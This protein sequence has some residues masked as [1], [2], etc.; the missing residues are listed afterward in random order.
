[1][2]NG[3][4]TFISTLEDKNNRRIDF[5]RWS[6]KKLKTVET[7]VREFYQSYNGL[8][9]KDAIKRGAINLKIYKTEFNGSNE[10][11][12]NIIPIENIYNL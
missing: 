7:K 10:Q 5:E 3:K 4:Q 6:Y 8:F 12:V 1:M 9:V 2:F 11:L